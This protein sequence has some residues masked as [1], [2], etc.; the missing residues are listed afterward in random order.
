[1]LNW[2]RR[3]DPAFYHKEPHLLQTGAQIPR[4]SNDAQ[5]AARLDVLQADRLLFVAAAI[6]A[7]SAYAV[8]TVPAVWTRFDSGLLGIALTVPVVLWRVRGRVRNVLAVAA[9][10]ALF[11]V[12][13]HPVSFAPLVGILAACAS[14]VGSSV[15]A[16]QWR[17]KPQILTWSAFSTLLIACA[18]GMTFNAPGVALH[19]RVEILTIAVA[20]L[21]VCVIAGRIRRAELIARPHGVLSLPQ[22]IVPLLNR[23]HDHA[24]VCW[25]V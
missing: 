13:T 14:I 6:V 19:L 4:Y 2:R 25:S 3:V 15:V 24:I 10:G 23:S 18:Y 12:H 17:V 11:G 1:M 21:G 20:Y 7:L 5:V 22:N 8:M 16:Q 9:I